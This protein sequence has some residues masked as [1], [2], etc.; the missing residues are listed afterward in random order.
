MEE[1]RIF[2]N[3]C[4]NCGELFLYNVKYCSV[5]G[6]KN[7]K[8]KSFIGD[9]E[10]YSYTK[11]YYTAEPYK[12]DAPYIIAIVKLNEGLKVMGRLLGKIK[13]KQLGI[14]V[15]VKF[16]AKDKEGFKFKLAEVR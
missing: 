13:E 14:G 2:G 16:V 1:N 6:F 7:F 9:G 5:C 11:I 4:C 3:V 10:I 15:P 12:K 8:E